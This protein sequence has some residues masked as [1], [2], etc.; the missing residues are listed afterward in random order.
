MNSAMDLIWRN[1][2]ESVGVGDICKAAKVNKGSF[3][4]FFASKEV[5]ACAALDENFRQYQL[6]LE[7]TFSKRKN[8][9]E[10]FMSLCDLQFKIQSDRKDTAGYVCGCPYTNLGLEQSSLN[11]MISDCSQKCLNRIKKYFVIAIEDAIGNGDVQVKDANKKADELFTYYL[12][13]SVRAT[14]AN[15]L[16]PIA[17][18]KSMFRQLLGIEETIKTAV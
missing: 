8:P 15:D 10:R 2:Y 11:Q 13:S 18:L 16:A 4:H 17:E 12:G 6:A 5:L 14:L 7:R 1:S 3:Y 9:I